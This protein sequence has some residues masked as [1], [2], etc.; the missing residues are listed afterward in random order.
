MADDMW[1]GFPDFPE[2]HSC[3]QAKQQATTTLYFIVEE[4]R[5]YLATCR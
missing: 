5:M 4:R 1:E 2:T 3:F